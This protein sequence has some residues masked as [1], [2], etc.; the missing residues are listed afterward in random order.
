MQ[1]R[2]P[3]RR[4]R[5]PAEGDP[6][7]G[8]S[9]QRLQRPSHPLGKIP[10]APVQVRRVLQPGRLQ[11]P[12]LFLLYAGG[13]QLVKCQPPGPFRLPPG[14][15]LVAGPQ[16]QALPGAGGGGGFQRRF[17][18]GRPGREPPQALAHLCLLQQR[19]PLGRQGTIGFFPQQ[20]PGQRI[21]VYV[22]AGLRHVA[23]PGKQL[24][25]RRKSNA[26]STTSP[27]YIHPAGKK[28]KT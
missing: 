21:C 22:G 6:P 28:D 27:E 9:R 26:H 3:Q 14:Q 5:Q 4:I 25:F 8:K 16:Q 19:G 24:R 17:Q 11:P 12:G 20:P 1:G 13:V 18:P 2:E 10:V 7:G 23:G 15:G